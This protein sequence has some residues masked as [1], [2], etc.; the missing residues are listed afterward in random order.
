MQPNIEKIKK[1]VGEK[2]NGNKSA[3]AREIGVDRAQISKI[4]KS[5]NCAGAQ[6]FGGLIMYC[7]KENLEF[8]DYIFFTC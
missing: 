5:G 6:F 8:K 7:E 3:F 2:F 1:L 4:L